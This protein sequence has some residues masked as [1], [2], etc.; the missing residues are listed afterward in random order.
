MS[1]EGSVEGGDERE[2]WRTKPCREARL[3][4]RGGTGRGRGKGGRGEG[5]RYGAAYE[6]REMR[7]H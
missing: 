4:A 6:D 5:D 2:G 7:K 1:V 3:R